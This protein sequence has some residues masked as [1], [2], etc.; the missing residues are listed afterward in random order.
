[1]LKEFCKGWNTV[2][3]KTVY[4]RNIKHESPTEIE[5]SRN[6][7]IHDSLLFPKIVLTL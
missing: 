1:M 3:E 7:H 5:K 4:L 2:I 6:Y